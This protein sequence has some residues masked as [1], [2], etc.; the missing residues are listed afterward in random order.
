M[1]GRSRCA[2][3]RFHPAVTAKDDTTSRCEGLVEYLHRGAR[4]QR[5]YI[6]KLISCVWCPPNL[7]CQL[8]AG[9]QGKKLV[10]RSDLQEGT[11]QANPRTRE[12]NDALGCDEISS[13]R[14]GR[15][16]QTTTAHTSSIYG[17]SRPR[18][19]WRCFRPR[20]WTWCAR[21]PR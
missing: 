12:R 18:W 13:I 19:E 4:S 8:A 2:P 6:P 1:Q 16:V 3:E 5:F 20:P 10:A 7:T 17:R 11:Q 14:I 21:R 15:F 9:R